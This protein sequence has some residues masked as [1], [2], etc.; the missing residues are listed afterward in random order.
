MIEIDPTPF[1]ERRVVI[2][3]EQKPQSNKYNQVLIGLKQFSLLVPYLGQPMNNPQVPE[4]FQQGINIESD[5]EHEY[6][7]REDIRTIKYE[8]ST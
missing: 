3:I 1:Y 7:F 2:F 5:M 6:E 4:S 8:K